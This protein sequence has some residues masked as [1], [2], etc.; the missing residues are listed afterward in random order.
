MNWDNLA[1]RMNKE[2]LFYD[3]LADYSQSK[4]STTGVSDAPG[5][6]KPVISTGVYRIELLA[7]ERLARICHAGKGP[8]LVAREKDLYFAIKSF[9]FKTEGYEKSENDGIGLVL[10][11]GGA[12]GAYEIGVWKAL[13]EVG[14][15]NRITG[16][17]GTSVGA[18]NSLLFILGDLEFAE[19]VWMRISDSQFRKESREEIERLS[20]KYSKRAAEHAGR[21]F[22]ML[23]KVIL[24]QAFVSQ[25]ELQREL[26][27]VMR[28]GAANRRRSFTAFSTVTPREETVELFL[29]NMGSNHPCFQNERD[30]HYVSWAT[31]SNS[32][33]VSLIIASAAIPYVY[34]NAKFQG[35]YYVDGGLFDNIPACPLYDC[36]FRKF[37][38]VSLESQT[39]PSLRLP[40]GQDTSLFAYFYP[41]KDF[42]DDFVATLDISRELTKQRIDLGY[43]E[44]LRQLGSQIKVLKDMHI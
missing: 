19:D 42:R 31:L 36:H 4:G 35:R 26:F 13:R 38:V 22:Q 32:E 37:L 18:I 24:E 23:G 1:N 7:E 2:Q 14:I 16:V 39:K 5:N 21:P 15:D 25:P 33:V 8:L 12:K 20:Q 10:A 3:F 40:K 27:R 43:H 44:T 28:E 29:K 11:G 30:S 17:S 41:G 9:L 6:W 34:E